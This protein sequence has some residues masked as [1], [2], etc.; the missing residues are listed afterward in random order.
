MVADMIAQGEL[1]PADAAAATPI[2]RL[3]QAEE[4]A[5]SVLWLCSPGPRSRLYWRC[6]ASNVLRPADR[7][8]RSGDFSCGSRAVERVAPAKPK[9]RKRAKSALTSEF[10]V[11]LNRI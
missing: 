7:R 8:C 10:S 9:V 1:N 6:A 2:A 5:A 11:G 4:I 3:G